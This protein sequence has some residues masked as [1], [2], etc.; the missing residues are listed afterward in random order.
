MALPFTVTWTKTPVNR[1]LQK[2]LGISTA[3]TATINWLIHGVDAEVR[4]IKKPGANKV[5]QQQNYF[6]NTTGGN[7]GL[8][9]AIG[10]GLTFRNWEDLGWS[11]VGENA[12]GTPIM[13]PAEIKGSAH[14]RPAVTVYAQGKDEG[15]IPYEV[16]ISAY[17]AYVHP[18]RRP[19]PESPYKEYYRVANLIPGAT[20]ANVDIVADFMRWDKKKG[21]LELHYDV[22]GDK[23]EL[24]SLRATASLR[25][26]DPSL[27]TSIDIKLPAKGGGKL[28]NIQGRHK[29]N[30][31]GKY[32]NAAYD[33]GQAITAVVDLIDKRSGESAD[34][35]DF[36]NTYSVEEVRIEKESGVVGDPSAYTLNTIA[37][38]MRIA[39]V[40]YVSISDMYRDINRQINTMYEKIQQEGAQY[41]LDLYV[42]DAVTNAYI[43]KITGLGIATKKDILKPHN[44]LNVASEYKDL[45]IGD[46]IAAAERVGPSN[47]SKHLYDP[48]RIP[49]LQTI[50][51]RP[52]TMDG[53]WKMLQDAFLGRGN[54]LPQWKPKGC[55]TTVNG[56]L[57]PSTN[58]R[59]QALHLEINQPF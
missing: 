57:S 14:P 4:V 24:G 27:G 40:S 44:S 34:V 58:P 48:R 29:I 33:P 52:S 31:P 59:D 54:G 26:E 42:N 23:K 13:G 32:I 16:Q 18:S 1:R 41:S 12:D 47:V 53:S 39:G 9:E 46:M 55:T 43:D 2:K 49:Q 38:A 21:G 5:Y 30:I 20:E 19:N 6:D 3:Y 17:D 51:L 22:K 50:D 8:I 7:P 36:N 10:I 37:R 15:K 25:L 28:S 56:L 35:Q 45:I 11:Q